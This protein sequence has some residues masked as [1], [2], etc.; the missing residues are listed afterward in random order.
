MLVREP[1]SCLVKANS[2]EVRKTKHA[3][4]SGAVAQKGIDF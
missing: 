3:Y 2:I 1:Q 4:D